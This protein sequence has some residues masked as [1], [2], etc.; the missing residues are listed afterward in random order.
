MFQIY[1]KNISTQNSEIS[2]FFLQFFIFNLI[3]L[4]LQEKS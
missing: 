3:Q 2:R 4:D 1:C